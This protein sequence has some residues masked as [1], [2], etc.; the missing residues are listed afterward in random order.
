VST[1]FTLTKLIPLLSC[2]LATSHCLSSAFSSPTSSGPQSEHL[3]AHFRFGC[4]PPS[5]SCARKLV[6]RLQRVIFAHRRPET[7]SRRRR[8]GLLL[9]CHKK[10]AKKAYKLGSCSPLWPADK[11]RPQRER[12]LQ[13]RPSTKENLLRLFFGAAQFWTSFCATKRGHQKSETGQKSNCAPPNEWAPSKTV[14]LGGETVTTSGFDCRPSVLN[15]SFWL[16]LGRAFKRW[17]VGRVLADNCQRHFCARRLVFGGRPF[18]WGPAML[19]FAREE[20]PQTG[21]RT[22]SAWG[23]VYLK[24]LA[25]APSG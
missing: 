18:V 25:A 17:R 10:G 2:P 13:W 5:K 8:V 9:F 16:D 21:G 23:G 20:R 3:S 7:R 19:G 6:P 24:G 12:E 4:F 14:P 1:Y 22:R 15:W 11:G